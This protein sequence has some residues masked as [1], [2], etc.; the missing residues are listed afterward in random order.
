[1]MFDAQLIGCVVDIARLCQ[2]RN[3]LRTSTPA[4]TRIAANPTDERRAEMASLH[5]R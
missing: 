3:F 4:K 5:S 2:L 1:M